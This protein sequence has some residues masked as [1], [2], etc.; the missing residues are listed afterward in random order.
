MSFPPIQD[1]LNLRILGQIFTGSACQAGPV[2]SH[3]KYGRASLMLGAIG[4]R[5]MFR[6]R[7]VGS[8]EVHY[9]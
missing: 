7:I 6:R 9:N 3:G 4:G 1:L 5:S 8:G 2:D